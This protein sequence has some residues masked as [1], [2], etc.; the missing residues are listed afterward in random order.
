MI[1]TSILQD[2]GA[3]SRADEIAHGI[4]RGAAIELCA[5]RVGDDEEGYAGH[6]EFPDF[7]QGYG[8]G[9]PC[10]DPGRRVAG[11]RGFPEGGVAGC[12]YFEDAQPPS[13]IV[14]RRLP[15]QPGD[16]VVGLS[17]ISERY[18]C[19]RVGCG[20]EADDG[21]VAPP[22]HHHAHFARC[23]PR[24]LRGE[25]GVEVLHDG[26]RARRR[27]DCRDYGVGHR[28]VARCLETRCHQCRRCH[29]LGVVG[30]EPCYRA[31]YE[32][33]VACAY[34]IGVGGGPC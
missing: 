6:V 33:G 29:V 9:R 10:L 3:E 24:E 7:W 28:L 26:G 19:E 14:A 2:G 25:Q 30:Y 32:R 31:V 16:G 23:L 20:M 27:V 12:R 21:V 11:C 17:R 13:G 15:Q 22:E 18:E 8:A 4:G 1:F 5:K 34:Y